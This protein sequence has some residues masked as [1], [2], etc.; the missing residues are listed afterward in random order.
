MELLASSLLSVIAL[1]MTYSQSSKVETCPKRSFLISTFAI[2][3][4][5][6][7]RRFECLCILV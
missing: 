7:K 2:P 5:T 3:F 4:I 1:S 6:T